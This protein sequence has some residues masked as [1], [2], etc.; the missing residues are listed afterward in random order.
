VF[1]NIARN[2]RYDL[3]LGHDT[4]FAIDISRSRLVH[5]FLQL[6]PDYIFLIDTDI[7]PFLCRDKKCE[8]FY[9]VVNYFIENYSKYDVI[10]VYHMN[11]RLE[12]NVYVFTEKR[13][14]AGF[15]YYDYKPLKLEIGTGV[16]RVDAMGI[17]IVMFK[18][19]VFE[20]IPYPWFRILHL[21]DQ[22]SKTSLEMGEDIYFFTQCKQ[23][24]IPVHVTTDVIALHEAVSY[25][26]PDGRVF[27]VNPFVSFNT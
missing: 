25:L 7:F 10:G 21:Y 9:D 23:H 17:G 6:N 11:K 27:V 12:P 19:E 18:P 3:V 1:A 14:F 8:I 5:A 4:H 22:E 26:T 13:N 15:E 20:K 2:V 16:H 24:N